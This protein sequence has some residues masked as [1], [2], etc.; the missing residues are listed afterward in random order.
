MKLSF[1][2][3]KK[4]FL[5]SALIFVLLLAVGFGFTSCENFLN[6]KGVKEEIEDIIAYNNAKTVN[7]SISCKEE[8]GSVFPSQTIQAKL[9]YDFEIQFIPNT[10]NYTI[11]D[12]AKI[13]E[14]VSWKDNTISRDDCVEFKAIEQSFEDKNSGLYRVKA[15]VIKA[16]D[17]IQIQP[18]CALLPSVV[19]VSPTPDSTEYNA[20]TTIIITV[21]TP[22]E[23]DDGEGVSI[24]YGENGIKVK[25]GSVDMTNCFELPVLSSDHTK[26]I[27]Q[28]KGD[29]LAAYMQN[30][31]YV[32]ITFTFGTGF[33]L[34]QNG[35]DIYFA[36]N[37]NSTFTMKFNKTVEHTDP[38]LYGLFGSRSEL[39]AAD[40]PSYNANDFFVVQSLDAF[41]TP[42][43][44]IRNRVSTGFYLSGHA[45][46]LDSGIS[47]IEVVEQRIKDNDA[48]ATTDYPEK[49]Q[50][51]TRENAE[52]VADENGNTYFCLFFPLKS[53][54]G[55]IK[56]T[57][58]AYDGCGNHT[59]K[60]FVVFKKVFNDEEGVP[61][62]ISNGKLIKSYLNEPVSE[63][64]IKEW[65]R[66]IHVQINDT[67]IRLYKITSDSDYNNQTV[68]IPYSA[69]NILCNYKGNPQSFKFYTR[70]D[71]E[72]SYGISNE[73]YFLLNTDRVS[74]STFTISVSDDMENSFQK[75]Y[76]IIDSSDF[77]YQMS[78]VTYGGQNTYQ[79]RF[80]SKSNSTI[81]G[82]AEYIIYDT[83][84]SEDHPAKIIKEYPAE[85]DCTVKVLPTF[86]NFFTDI[87]DFEVNTQTF[88][89]DD[90]IKEAS[91]VINPQLNK[92]N[93]AEVQISVE[94]NENKNFDYIYIYYYD[95][96]DTRDYIYFPENTLS[97]TIVLNPSMITAKTLDQFY[98]Y[99]VYNK[100]RSIPYTLPINPDKN[101]YPDLDIEP[102][103]YDPELRHEPF[104][105]KVNDY[106]EFTVEDISSGFNADNSYIKIHK[107]GHEILVTDGLNQVPIYEFDTGDNIFTIHLEDNNGKFCHDTIN[108]TLSMYGQERF[109]KI[110]YFPQD[111]G[112]FSGIDRWVLYS[113]SIHNSLNPNYEYGD[114][115]E[116]VS[117]GI[118]NSL[119]TDVSYSER[120]GY[121]KIENSSIP[122]NGNAF[123]KIE[124]YDEYNAK[125]YMP[126]PFYFYPNISKQ[127]SGDYDYI[128]TKSKTEFYIVSDAPVFVHT[129]V[130][131]TSDS[132]E[133]CKNWTAYE[134]LTYNR[135]FSERQYDLPKPDPDEG[136][137]VTPVRYTVTSDIL[138]QINKNEC[139]C[140]IAHFADGSTFVSDV[141][142]KE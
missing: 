50:S 117:N 97:H 16:A 1:F 67:F 66:K 45:Y 128:Q 100:K 124:N 31:P 90:A 125:D 113:E 33:K 34:T 7:V 104:K 93:L 83:L 138:N 103:S 85:A 89:N 114:F 49:T 47:R 77:D 107:T 17:D 142:K 22:L 94:L 26:I 38:K 78:R 88:T 8:I 65:L 111:E 98:I 58:T 18:N 129:V 46:D 57:V 13:F 29:V 53:K 55:A 41:D 116:F 108:Y 92:D 137:P 59:S 81:S 64:I 115:Y 14:A 35:T 15:K 36:Q 61:V 95:G 39:H 139:Y 80:F 75:E 56:I 21:N 70:D 105:H 136:I 134:W 74:G 110:K 96:F 86:R 72:W 20:N 101:R 120:E 79:I 130:A 10:Q 24:P 82:D 63:D 102:P 2:N 112:P 25:Y 30:V 123:I 9:G 126:V 3:S 131:Q 51:F 141:F 32:D 122:T 48:Q 60:D 54:N 68:K 43:E 11:K 76:S 37:E 121:V 28:P 87:P 99:A 106:V 40:V 133:E 119:A 27:I 91:A 118:W 132:Y 135:T 42:D 6:A 109:S 73:G 4:T 140:V 62:F 69:L 71:E 5:W 23:N 127:N 19:S 12:P 44:I 84:D 52:F